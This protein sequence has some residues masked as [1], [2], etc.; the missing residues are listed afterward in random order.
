M[1]SRDIKFIGE[2]FKLDML[3]EKIMNQC[4]IKLLGDVKNPKEEDMEALCK[5]LATIGEKLDHPK[6]TQYMTQYFDRIREISGNL[7]LPSRIRFMMDDLIALRKSRW[8]PR[9]DTNAPKTIKEVHKEAAEKEK[10]KEKEFSRMRQSGGPG[11]IGGPRGGDPRGMGGRPDQRGGYGGASGGGRG[12]AQ[13]QRQQQQQQEPVADGW[14]TAP[15]RRGGRGG[16]A[17]DAGA[18]RRAPQ[19]HTALAPAGGLTASKGWAS[20]QEKGKDDKFNPPRGNAFD[21][22]NSQRSGGGRGDGGRQQQQQQQQQQQAQ[23]APTPPP[24]ID[25]EQAESQTGV[26]L[27]EF[28]AS[29]DAKE[30]SACIKELNAGE[31]H[32]DIV[33]WILVSVLEKKEPQ[34]ISAANLFQALRVDNVI[35][36]DQLTEG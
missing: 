32:A 4:I 35:T 28:L 18:P 9:R 30:A 15:T 8:V 19:E 14:E 6:A 1:T 10:E 29:G 2:L 25:A 27:E 16:G 5:L 31:F 24:A 11:P 13:P 22:L 12:G 23:R 34:A 33:N 7:A 26:I 36:I 21:A 3:T 17:V 20:T